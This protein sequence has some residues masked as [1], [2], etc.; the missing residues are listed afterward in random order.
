MPPQL[1]NRVFDS[2]F[3][4]RL[5]ASF[6]LATTH[7]KPNLSSYVNRSRIDQFIGVSDIGSLYIII[8]GSLY[9][10]LVVCIL[11]W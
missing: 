5:F 10:I 9:I 1:C 3:P 11:Y 7:C 8:I 6:S 2:P 4:P